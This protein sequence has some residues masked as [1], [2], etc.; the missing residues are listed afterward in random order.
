MPRAPAE[1]TKRG[2]PESVQVA[3]RLHLLRTLGDVTRRVLQRHAALIQRLPAPSPSLHGPA[4]GLSR[5]RLD[6]EASREETRATMR[7]RFEPIHTLAGN[8]MHQ[9]AIAR[10]LSL[11]RQTVYKYLALTVPPERHH[12][13]PTV[14]ALAPYEGYLLRR[15]AAGCHNA[16]HLWRELRPQGDPGA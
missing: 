16:R 5:L 4:H 13:R 2:A 12:A 3:D 11:N 10:Q 7:E 6:R 15:W 1:G 8:G 14:S 9:A